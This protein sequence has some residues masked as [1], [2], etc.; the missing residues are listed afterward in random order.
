VWSILGIALASSFAPSSLDVS[1]ARLFRHYG[2][3]QYVYCFAIFLYCHRNFD[4]HSRP[5]FSELCSS[6]K[7]HSDRGGPSLLEVPVEAIREPA[8]AAQLGAPLS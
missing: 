2:H 8:R 4:H 5:S 3:A 1:V 6:L 7:D